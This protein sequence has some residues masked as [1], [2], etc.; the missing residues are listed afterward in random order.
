MPIANLKVNL[1]KSTLANKLIEYL[2]YHITLFGV[3]QPNSNLEAIQQLK[4]PKTW[5]QRAHF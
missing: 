2:G 4:L 3:C 1:E 5:N